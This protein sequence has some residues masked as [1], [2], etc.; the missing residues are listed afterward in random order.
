MWV[1]T[2]VPGGVVLPNFFVVGA[3][4][5]GTTA[6][7]RCLRA[8]PHIYLSPIK[9]PHFFARD[10]KPEEFS[11]WY[12]KTIPPDYRGVLRGETNE[13]LHCAHIR[14]WDEYLR[15]FQGANGHA[16]IGE[17]SNSYLF[18]KNAARAIH[19]TLDDAKIL[20]VLRDPVERAYSDY[21]MF[22]R[23]GV[24]RCSFRRALERSADVADPRWGVD[25]CLINAGL[26]YEQVK[27]YFDL[28]ERGAVKILLYD[29]L[30]AQSAA[31]LRETLEFL[32]VD[33]RLG[34]GTISR[35]NVGLVPRSRLLNAVLFHTGLKNRLSRMAPKSL[36][37]RLK[38]IYYAARSGPGLSRDDWAWAYGFFARDVD[39][40][41]QLI[42]IDLGRWKYR[43]AGRL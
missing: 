15:L 10:I 18:S 19:A 41:E 35:H 14:E 16:A 5:A 26:Y 23:I 20:M 37:K 4:K 43:S 12:R 28:F 29:D 42:G 6:L 17:M 36:K 9:E 11:D 8:H 39:A 22:T 7:F 40:L 21:L 38:S 34:P 25:L 32:G 27:R 1:R 31:T 13:T 24:L 2:Q 3:A 33:P 30:V